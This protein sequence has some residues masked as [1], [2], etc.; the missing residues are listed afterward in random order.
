MSFFGTGAWSWRGKSRSW[1]SRWP[2]PWKGFFMLPPRLIHVQALDHHRL[3]VRFAN[4]DAG[5]LDLQPYL[6]FGVFSRLRDPAVFAQ[7]KIGFDTVEW[8]CGVDLDPL[9][10]Y[11][12]ARMTVMAKSG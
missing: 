10:V 5:E 9:F 12:K 2:E 6:D 3:A 11:E 1:C 4:G 8:P 7:A